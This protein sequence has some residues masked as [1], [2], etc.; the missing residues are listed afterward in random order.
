[1]EPEAGASPPLP[2]QGQRREEEAVEEMRRS[3]GD[4]GKPETWDVLEATS[5]KVRTERGEQTDHWLSLCGGHWGKGRKRRNKLAGGEIL[6]C[7]TWF[8]PA[9]LS[10]PDVHPGT[11]GGLIHP[12]FNW[13]G[14]ANAQRGKKTVN[15]GEERF[16][17][18]TS[19]LKLE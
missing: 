3:L 19:E 5:G 4:V 2:V 6:L 7:H 1:M 8:S 16:D 15:T 13:T 11:A 10:I 9:A 14:A 12:E 17:V 18:R